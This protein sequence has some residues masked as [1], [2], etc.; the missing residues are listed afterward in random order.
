MGLTEFLALYV[1]RHF[2][3]T[4]GTMI[5]TIRYRLGSLA[6]LMAVALG[7]ATAARQ[8][9]FAAAQ[10][11]N[12]AA[13]RQYSW[14]SRTTLKLAGEVKQT[15]LEDVRYDRDGRLQKDLISGGPAP[16]DDRARRGGRIRARIAAR[17]R[18][19]LKDTLT[20]LATLAESYA[21][22]GPERLKGFAGATLSRGE[23]RDAGTVQV[24]GRDIVV[25]GDEMTAWID[26]ATR[27]LRRVS[28]AT[29]YDSHP[30]TIDVDYERLDAGVTYPAHS[31][32][33]YPAKSLEVVVDTFEYQRSGSR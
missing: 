27:A 18:A 9:D 5:E 2:R 28:I 24:R 1:R 33:A 26:P 25:T 16:D 11:A 3:E 7:T 30:L 20:E 19:E 31:T 21:H 23:G 13:L 8:Q 4:I 12:Q 6:L 10:Q 32:L 22:A 14:K 29:T 15:R 17:K